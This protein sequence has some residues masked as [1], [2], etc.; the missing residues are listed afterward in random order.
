MLTMTP[1]LKVL[2]EDNHLLVVDKPAEIPTMGAAGEGLT[3]L[4]M[5]KQYVRRRYNK[6]GNVYLGVVSRLD[7]LVTGVLVF[8]RTSKA[9]ARLS[10][11]FRDGVVEK[12][13]QAI[14]ERAPR[15]ARGVCENY[16]RK[17]E[18]RRKVLVHATAV[19]GARLA[20]LSYQTLHVLSTGQAFVEVD[21]ETGRKHQ[22]RVQLAHCGWP[23]LGDSKYGAVSP[24][25][26]GI[27]LHAAKLA[28]MHPVTKELCSWTAPPPK[29]WP[30]IPGQQR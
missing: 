30:R 19:A 26:C 29:Y 10:A 8:A 12:T 21:L 27:A 25:P 7:S 16:L 28:L 2:Y 14:V 13:Y 1:R 24:F 9:A 18:R 6:P 22:I 4:D 17:D 3:V 11:Q 23:I 15:P 20:K 5:A